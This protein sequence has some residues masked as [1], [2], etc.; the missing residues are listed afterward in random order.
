SAVS[1][2]PRSMAGGAASLA[3][4]GRQTGTALG[5]AISGTIVGPALARGGAAF[6][7]AAHGAGWRGLG[8]GLGVVVAGRL[9]TRRWAPATPA[10][11]A[12]LFEG[13][14]TGAGAGTRHT[15]PSHAAEQVT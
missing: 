9:S 10:R 3:S 8:V 12:A 2:M 13:V 15:V 5:V 11:A 7:G 1:G 4:A 14:D 6:P